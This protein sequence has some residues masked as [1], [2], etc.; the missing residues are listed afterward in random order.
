MS[1]KKWQRKDITTEQVLWACEYRDLNKHK[2]ILFLTDLLC[3]A[4]GA[5][6]KVVVRALERENR[7]GMIEYGVSLRTAWMT[8]KGKEYMDYW[9]DEIN[10]I[11]SQPVPNLSHDS[12]IDKNH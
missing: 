2:E 9:R 8:D 1:E 12:D 10:K 3:E 7:N 5:P 4:T 6:E 11:L